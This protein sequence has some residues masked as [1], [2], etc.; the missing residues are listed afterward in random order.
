MRV[1]AMFYA[2]LADL[3]GGRERPMDAPAGATAADV[4]R[5]AV[6]AAPRLDAMSGRV[7]VA[8]NAEFARWDAPLGEGDEVAFLPP[9]SG[10]SGRRT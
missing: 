4:W 10:G 3:A 7:S 9:V 6:G 1:T 8:I 2:R 5:L